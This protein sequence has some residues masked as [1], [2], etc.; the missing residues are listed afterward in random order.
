MMVHKVVIDENIV[1]MPEKYGVKMF[2]DLPDLHGLE[3]KVKILEVGGQLI[4]SNKGT[5][6]PPLETFVDTPLTT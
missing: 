5:D 4:N 2:Y 6:G 1:I 3:L